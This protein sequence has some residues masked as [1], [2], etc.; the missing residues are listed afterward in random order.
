M[1]FHLGLWG[2]GPCYSTNATVDQSMQLCDAL[3]T[4]SPDIVDAH[5]N[6]CEHRQAKILGCMID[7]NAQLVCKP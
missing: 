6:L 2:N 7:N 5:V 4:V 1:C 3:V